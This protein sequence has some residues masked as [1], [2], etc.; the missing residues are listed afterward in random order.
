MRVRD[1]SSWGHAVSSDLY[2]WSMQP[3]VLQCR[4]ANIQGGSVL[5]DANNTSGLFPDQTD[6][7][8]AIYTQHSWVTG[9]RELA[10][11]YSTDGGY[12]F[13]KYPKGLR[14]QSPAGN[15]GL[16]EPK[17]VWYEQ[18]SQW[19]M[20]AVTETTPTAIGIYTSPNLIDW[21]AASEFTNQDLKHLG[22]RFEYPNLVPIP[23]INST[24]AKD[25]NLP[26]VPGG[27]LHDYGDY[28]LVSSSTGSPL[29]GGSVTRYFPGKFNGTHFQ[30]INNRT[31]RYIDFGPDNY[32]SQ[33]FFGLSSKMP[34]V[35]LGM[36]SNLQ[37]TLSPSDRTRRLDYTSTFTSPREG[38]LIPGPG[39]GDLS[40]FSRPFGLEDLRDGILANFSRP[41]LVDSSVSYN[42]SE[43]VLV[44]AKFEM[45]PPNDEEVD[46]NLDFIFKSRKSSEKILCTII[47]KTW[48]A[49]FGCDRSLAG[50]KSAIDNSPL[51]QMS[52]LQVRPLLPF[53]NPAVRRWE[54]QA[55]MDGYILETFLNK[56]VK[57]GTII[58]SPTVLMDSVNFQSSKIPDWATLSMTVQKLRPATS[59]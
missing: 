28:I 27:T 7:V 30:P 2:T 44:E 19:V 35:S 22:H 6:G 9:T 14:F 20:T 8:V 12:T 3:T 55:I 49:D 58:I 26:T 51:D 36:A 43:A 54:I 39:E 17:I 47:F 32:A 1:F 13:I 5:I 57:A 15:Q 41:H 11:A 23:R 34:V 40:Y 46:L 37:Y 31:D 42:G 38:Y 10:S 29:H 21:I 45:Q 25:P 53:H 56:G 33:F 18:T 59:T 4:D 52:A 16:L 24:G 50:L 48:T